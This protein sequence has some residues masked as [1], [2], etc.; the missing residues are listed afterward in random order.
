MR[1]PDGQVVRVGDAVIID[2]QYQG[3]VVGC[4]EEGSYLTPESKEQWGFLQGG[5]LIDTSFG[6][7][8]HYPDEN[9]LASEPVVLA[10]RRQP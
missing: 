6:G 7:I 2:V 9:A 10:S 3:T 5:V 4:I 1:Y 8:V